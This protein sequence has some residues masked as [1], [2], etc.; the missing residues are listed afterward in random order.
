M[1]PTGIA[2]QDGNFEDVD[3]ATG[4][5]VTITELMT[6]ATEYLKVDYVFWGTQEPYYSEHVI[7]FLRRV[8]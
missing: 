4:K 6:F 8:K 7:P 1:V 3:P 2:V 5:P